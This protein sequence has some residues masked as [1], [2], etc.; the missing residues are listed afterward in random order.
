MHTRS[1]LL[2]SHPLTAEAIAAHVPYGKPGAYVLG[3]K[4]GDVFTVQAVGRADADLRQSLGE[5]AAEGRYQGF[6]YLPAASADEAFDVSCFLFHEFGGARHLDSAHP[7]Q[8]PGANWICPH[9]SIFGVRDWR[10][11][12]R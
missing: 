4:S 11:S 8:P 5:R 3:F 1:H 6:K 7:P 10:A 9:C 2:G 12:A